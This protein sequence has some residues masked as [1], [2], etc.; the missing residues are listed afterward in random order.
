MAVTPKTQRSVTSQL[1]TA[2]FT[3]AGV[4]EDGHCIVVGS[5]ALGTGTSGAVTVTAQAFGLSTVRNVVMTSKETAS[6]FAR[7]IPAAGGKTVVV[8]VYNNNNGDNGSSDNGEWS[9]VAAGIA[10]GAGANS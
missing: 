2:G 1:T 4:V 10:A 7:A 9:F 3:S 5:V 8:T 6:L